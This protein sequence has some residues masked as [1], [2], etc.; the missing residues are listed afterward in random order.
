MPSLLVRSIPHFSVS[1][2]ISPGHGAP[3]A[4]GYQSLRNY[5]PL[6]FSFSFT[7]LLEGSETWGIRKLGGF[8]WFPVNTS[9]CLKDGV[10][11]KKT[12]PAHLEG[13]P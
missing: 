5:K 2:L 4:R 10:A 12:S 6:S 11:S 3:E 13:K 1:C 7:R 9:P 8:L